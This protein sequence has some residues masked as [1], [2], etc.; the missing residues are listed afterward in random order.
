MTLLIAV[1]TSIVIITSILSIFN[2]KDD[3]DKWIKFPNAEYVKGFKK[4]KRDKDDYPSPD[5]CVLE[6]VNYQLKV[7]FTHYYTMVTFNDLMIA[8]I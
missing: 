1:K 2:L 5:E 8:A 7:S 3:D 6:L 4:K